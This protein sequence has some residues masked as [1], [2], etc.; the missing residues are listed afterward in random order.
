M[1][2]A[3][4]LRW[5]VKDFRAC[6][7]RS[8]RLSFLAYD[9]VPK[10]A[11]VRET[12]GFLSS[13]KTCFCRS[14]WPPAVTHRLWFESHPSDPPFFVMSFR[15]Q[16]ARDVVN[17]QQAYEAETQQMFQAWRVKVDQFKQKFMQ[18]C[19]EA[20]ARRGCFHYDD[21]V[22]PRNLLDRGM[23]EDVLKQP[24][25]EL[26]VELDFPEGKVTQ[27][28]AE[29]C[30]GNCVS[31]HRGFR[32]HVKWSPE[33]ATGSIPEPHSQTTR[34]FCTTCPICHEHRPAVALMP[35]GHV[36][37]RDCHR[38][39]QLRQCPMCRGPITSATNGLFM[40]WRDLI[41]QW[42]H[43]LRWMDLDRFLPL[44]FW[45]K[46]EKNLQFWRVVRWA[47]VVGWLGSE[48][49]LC[50][51]HVEQG[52]W[53]FPQMECCKHQFVDFVSMSPH[54]IPRISWEIWNDCFITLCVC[55][56][57]II[58]KCGRGPCQHSPSAAKSLQCHPGCIVELGRI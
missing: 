12:S 39:Q 38:C 30:R 52:A 18:G 36:I 24:L 29:E 25:Q 15:Q 20:A 14:I 17:A 8:L 54:L 50:K 7:W 57:M 33:D 6:Q 26:L 48:E 5:K 11:T 2:D 23:S 9:W 56:I 19:K 51:L 13:L 55:G 42:W 47:V 4:V 34:G 16:L 28:K 1:I 37:C 49:N 41:G 31:Y 22:Q 35:C 46:T 53:P 43:W 32:I 10:C 21:I 3:F 40:D 58:S 27:C 45:A 44:P